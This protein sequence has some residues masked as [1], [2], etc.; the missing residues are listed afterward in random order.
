VGLWVLVAPPVS[1]A[2]VWNRGSPVRP[3]WQQALAP[4]VVCTSALRSF[5]D[6]RGFY[7]RPM[8]FPTGCR[9]S[10]APPGSRTPMT[11]PVSNSANLGASARLG[12]EESSDDPVESRGADCPRRRLTRPR[13]PN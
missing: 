7:V 11:P 9:R 1:R 3:S 5:E 4:A 13:R 6:T 2:R 12:Q 10:N 8:T